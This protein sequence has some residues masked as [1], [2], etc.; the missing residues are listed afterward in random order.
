MTA[1]TPDHARSRYNERSHAALTRALDLVPAY[2]IWRGRDAGPGASADERF[3]GM[4][5]FTKAALKEFFP[6]GLVPAGQSVEE[7]LRRGEI[8]YVPTSGTTSER[9]F[10]LWHQTWWDASERLSWKL[11]AHLSAAGLGGHREA[12]LA[13]P[14]SVGRLDPDRQLSMDERCDGRILFLN[15]QPDPT[16]WT[17]EDFERMTSELAR[18]APKVL[19]ANPTF[20][21]HWAEWLLKRGRT[22]YQPAAIVLT[23]EFPSRLA[24]RTIA[25][26]FGVPLVSSHGTTETGYVFT[27]CEC[28][29]HHQ[30]ADSCR[31]DFHPW[32]ESAGGPRRGRILVTPFDNPWAVFVRFDPGDLVT[33]AEKP[34]PCGRRAGLTLAAMEGRGHDLTRNCAGRPV[35]V[36]DVDAA[37]AVEPGLLQYQLRQAESGNLL[38]WCRVERP[39]MRTEAALRRAL[40]GLY[41]DAAPLEIA[42]VKAIA[43]EVSG[44]HRLTIAR[45]VLDTESLLEPDGERNSKW[46]E[47]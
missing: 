26:A 31:V 47:W 24:R 11:N 2:R 20:L 46:R 37:L 6:Q 23:F 38:L 8:V 45:Q 41:G 1:P 17:D 5:A 30:V 35:T 43:P 44:K 32:K 12:L 9:H 21:A 15:G 10:N 42:F 40:A 22:P 39:A 28:G 3:A 36:N 34:C 33:L 4:P 7:G 25:A 16:L 18:F 13:S 19:E 27:E 14:L 29:S